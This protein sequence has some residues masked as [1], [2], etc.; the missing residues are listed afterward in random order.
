MKRLMVLTASTILLLGGAGCPGTP[1]SDTPSPETSS[2][3]PEPEGSFSAS[4]PSDQV[5]IQLSNIADAIEKVDDE[6]SAQ[7]A[8]QEI[9]KASIALE[10]L[11][12][13]MEGMSDAERTA[14]AQYYTAKY[15]QQQVRI[16]SAL[17]KLA[18]NPEWM[19]IITDEMKKMPSMG[20]KL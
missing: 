3:P 18:Q 10:E 1:E 11:G 15:S 5:G 13:S 19:T 6:A 8:A 17:R 4:N 14:A 16:M 7:A 2:N 9:A 12:K 20:R